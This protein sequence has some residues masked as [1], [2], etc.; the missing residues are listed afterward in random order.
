MTNI[1]VP[2]GVSLDG[3]KLVTRNNVI[4]V[5]AINA[6]SDPIRTVGNKQRGDR[7]NADFWVQEDWSGGLGYHTHKGSATDPNNTHPSIRG[8]FDSTVETR[9]Q[10]QVTLAEKVQTTTQDTAADNFYRFKR[11]GSTLYA[12]SEEENKAVAAY[13]A[14]DPDWRD[15]LDMS[16]GYANLVCYAIFEHNGD[17]YAFGGD[18]ANNT[19][20]AFGLRWD[21]GTWA[22]F[23]PSTTQHH[24]VARSGLSFQDIMY[25]ATYD[26]ADDLVRIEQ[27]TDD[28]NTW[29]I[30]AGMEITEANGDTVELVRYFDGAG[31][32]AVYL[33]TDQG[34]YLLDFANSDISPVI[35]FNVATSLSQEVVFNTGR[36]EVWNGMLYLPRGMALVEFHYSGTWR[37]ISFLSQAK[38]PEALKVNTSS[39]I[40]AISASDQ[41]LFVGV[42]TAAKNSVWAYDGEGYHYIWSVSAQGAA[43][44]V[45]SL[46]DIQIFH[47][48]AMGLDQLHI[49]YDN[50]G[51][52][53][54]HRLDYVLSDPV[55][56]ASKPY[57]TAGLLVT[58]WFDAGMTDVDS[59]ILASAM[60]FQDVDA[61]ETIKVETAVNFSSSYESD[62]DRI[63]TF[64]NT[65]SS[66]DIFR[67]ESGAGFSGKTW[68]HKYTFA[69][70]GSTDSPIM[71]YPITYFEK[72]FS[73]LSKYTFDV[74]MKKSWQIN[75]SSYAS[76]QDLLKA[77]Q[78]SKVKVPLLA[79]SYAGTGI[80]TSATRYVRIENM[81]RADRPASSGESID[82]GDS[83]EAFVRIEVG[84]RL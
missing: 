45:H 23:T 77:L 57:E 40:G 44:Q 13:N 70:A 56:T 69:S 66:G 39:F 48:K 34:L 25:L 41:W 80:N 79:F 68:R 64:N 3:I 63:K 42:S 11:A 61:S 43:G 72:V 46:R 6:W 58:P 1:S 78:A 22:K 60:G 83:D 38:L 14:A 71:Y 30:I 33:H 65:D 29:A 82:G 27:S 19:V 55:E 20:P 62:S 2:Q 52:H 32:P 9:W 31:T 5:E 16:S 75:Q 81:P 15:A 18:Q 74:D 7:I 76:E 49:V 67:Y 17:M 12:F 24:D 37:D 10:G 4:Q 35:D 36:P 51:T 59:V 26:T 50:S 8:F 73:D 54:M 47:D 28:G 84:E 53:V 21:A